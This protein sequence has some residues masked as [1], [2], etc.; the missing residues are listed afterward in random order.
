[1]RTALDSNILSALFTVEP[2][3]DAVVAQLGLCRTQGPLIISG[4][5]YSEIHAVPNMTPAL[6][7]D[8]LG[9]TGIHVETSTSLDDW[10]L[11]GEVFAAYA[12]R[13]RKSGGGEPKRLLAD[14]MVGTHAFRSCDRL[15]TLDPARY[16]T[17]FPD[18]L[19]L[20]LT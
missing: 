2:A 14:F 15:F 9:D 6:L 19:L 1:M 3:S 7:Q 17:S 20:G 11:S 4:V 16:A 10:S 12:D 13:R 8:F 5:V 18:L